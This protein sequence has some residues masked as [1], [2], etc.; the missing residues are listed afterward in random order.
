MNEAFEAWLVTMLAD[1]APVR[2]EQVVLAQR[3]WHAL[4]LIL[5]NLP[6][7]QAG[8]SD[9]GAVFQMAWDRDKHHFTI[10]FHEIGTIDLFYRYREDGVC[11]WGMDLAPGE[12]FL[13]EIARAVPYLELF[14]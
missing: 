5:P 4:L 6:A 7:P 14:V 8:M 11:P 2:K 10:D 1:P 13:T 3:L 12:R 9:D